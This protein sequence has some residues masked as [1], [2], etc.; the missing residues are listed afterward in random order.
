MWTYEDPQQRN[1]SHTHT[2]TH[3]AYVTMLTAS[4]PPHPSS[5]YTDPLALRRPQL[6]LMEGARQPSRSQIQVPRVKEEPRSAVLGTPRSLFCNKNLFLAPGPALWQAW[7]VCDSVRHCKGWRW[8]VHPSLEAGRE[9][10]N[11]APAHPG[12]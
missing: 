4:L 5:T 1:P 11:K 8:G 6:D 2:H 3:S 12:C 7:C 10:K 9:L